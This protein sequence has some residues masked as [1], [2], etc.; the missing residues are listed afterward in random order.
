MLKSI[1]RR[2]LINI[3]ILLEN[4]DGKTKTYRTIRKRQQKL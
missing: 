1:K 3:C 4:I 2:F